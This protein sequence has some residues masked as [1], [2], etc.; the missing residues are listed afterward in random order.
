MA[1]TVPKAVRSRIMST[2]HSKDTGPEMIVRRGLFSRG[3]RY[4]LYV[5]LLPGKPDLVFPKHRA[6][7]FVHGCFWHG[8]NCHRFRLPASNREYWLQKIRR[9]QANDA[10]NIAALEALGWRVLV[11]WECA[12]NGKGGC[13]DATLD[14][15]ATWLRSE[16]T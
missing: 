12:I 7:I 14:A 10:R 9:N 8:H 16:S 11:V 5:K 3:L 6:I 15:V 1:D 4:R 13:A 2:V